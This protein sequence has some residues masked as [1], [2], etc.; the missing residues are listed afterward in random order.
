VATDWTSPRASPAGGAWLETVYGQGWIACG[1][2][3]LTFDPLSS[4]GLLGALASG[5]SAAHAISSDDTPTAFADIAV[6]HADIRA[7]YSARRIAAYRGEHRWAQRAFWSRQSGR[8][9]QQVPVPTG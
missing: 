3:A 8:R 2:A 4:Q 5:V 6:R 7:I 1:D 9:S